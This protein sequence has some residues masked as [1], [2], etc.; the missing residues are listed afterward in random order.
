VILRL[1]FAGSADTQQQLTACFT[2]AKYSGDAVNTALKLL[3]PAAPA[4]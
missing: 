3:F 4:K 2:N 1:N